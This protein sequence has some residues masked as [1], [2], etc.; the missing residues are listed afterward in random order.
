MT[1]K[2]IITPHK[3]DL[4][5]FSVKRLLPNKTQNMVGPWIF[6]DHMGP[7]NFDAGQ[8]INV[9]P[10]PHINLAAVTYLFEGEIFHRDSLGNAQ[11]ILP[12][13]INLMIAGK[14]IVH[15]ERER[16]EVRN[17]THIQH[18]LQLWHA[19]PESQEEI[20]PSFH[21]YEARTLPNFMHNNAKIR[22]MIGDAYD[23]SSPVKHFTNTLYVEATI[24]AES[25]IDIPHAEELGVY[26]VSG[27]ILIDDQEIHQYHMAILNNNSKHIKTVTN[28][29]V[30]I[31]GG[32]TTSKRYIEWNFVS[33]KKERIEKAKQDWKNRKFPK[34]P[35]DDQEFIP[36]PE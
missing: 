7:A 14:G 17:K 9:R 20:E 27:S 11:A 1:I 31:I 10:H 34:I 13:D 33:S 4:G 30:A 19:L 8:G 23:M 28:A 3:K 18:G 5:G 2:H 16:D 29:R 15:S 22:V 26:V 32:D 21:H 12:G 35:G 36:L 6:F 24:D 25:S